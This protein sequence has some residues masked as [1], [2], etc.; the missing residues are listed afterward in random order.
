M[1]VKDNTGAL[2]GEVTPKSP[3][4]EAGLKEGDVIIEFNGKKVDDDAHLRLMTAQT[5]PGTK[6]TVK[7]IRFPS[8][9]PV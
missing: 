3:A 8:V 2:I 9:Q 7:V 4:A 6:V 1:S 5:P